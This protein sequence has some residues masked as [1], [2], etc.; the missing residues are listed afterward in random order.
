MGQ[1][2][3]TDLLIVERGGL[4]YR[5]TPEELAEFLNTVQDV[6]VTAIADRD[7]LTEADVKVGDRVFVGDATADAEVDAGWAIYRVLTAT[8]TGATYQK[9]QEQES[10]DVTITAPSNLSIG[11]HDATQLVIGN[12]NGDGV[13]LP[14]VSAT[15]AGL[16]TPTMALNSHVAATAGSTPASNPVVVD[17]ATQQVSF[18]IANLDPLP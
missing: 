9:I 13:I 2:L 16:A 3:A 12:D 1:I 14:V 5:F 10:M 18:S 11:T 4:Q 17:A 7:V 6:S 8:A 15:K